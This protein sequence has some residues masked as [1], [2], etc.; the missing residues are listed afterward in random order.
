MK[1]GQRPMPSSSTTNGPLQSGAQEE[2]S[3]TKSAGASP[4][5]SSTACCG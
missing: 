2:R 5:P 4:M 3:A 1:I